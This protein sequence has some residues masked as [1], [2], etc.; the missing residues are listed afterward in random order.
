M[1]VSPTWTGR[2]VPYEYV[3]LCDS[4]SRIPRAQPRYTQTYTRPEYVSCNRN[5]YS[6]E[7]VHIIIYFNTR[8]A[9][10]PNT[11][12]PPEPLGRR[13]KPHLAT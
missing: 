5:S 2:T 7:S 10:T 4:Y 8:G 9:R 3:L 12:A 11:V 6:R 1:G 13:S